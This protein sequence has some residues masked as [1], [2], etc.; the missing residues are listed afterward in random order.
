MHAPQCLALR[1]FGDIAV[2]NSPR[3]ERNKW[4]NGFD[5]EPP[6]LRHLVFVKLHLP[7]SS[8]CPKDGYRV[9]V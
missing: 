7:T 8:F 2:Q 1:L 9:R 3:C 4:E 6:E 5:I